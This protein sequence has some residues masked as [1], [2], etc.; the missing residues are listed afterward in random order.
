MTEP[1]KTDFR[2][3]VLKAEI[4]KMENAAF[5]GQ[6]IS[7]CVFYLITS[8]LLNYVRASA[9]PWV[10]WPLIAIQLLQYFFI[11]IRCYQR[12]IILGL[13]RAVAAALFLSVMVAG[14]VENWETVIIPVT[15]AM[16]LFFSAKSK[17][18]S[19]EYQEM[20]ISR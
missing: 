20:T 4:L 6:I 19:A 10:L 8:L 12:S 9:A 13:N 11:F 14:R 7:L 18:V 2:G 5:W 17:N 1:Q 15:V 3:Q 16:L